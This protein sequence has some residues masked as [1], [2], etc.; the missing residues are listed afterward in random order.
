[1]SS[2]HAPSSRARR[3]TRRRSARGLTF[4]ELAVI[5]ATMGALLRL[6]VPNFREF[7]TRASDS[8]AIR[9][10]SDLKSVLIALASTTDG[11]PTALVFNQQGPGLLPAPFDEVTLSDGMRINYLISLHYPGFFDLYALEVSHENGD[12]YYRMIEINNKRI[13]QVVRKER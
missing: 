3:V 9:V 1:M 7:M 5:I 10:Y 2:P 4:V 6:A 11:P 8:S 12:H 13:E